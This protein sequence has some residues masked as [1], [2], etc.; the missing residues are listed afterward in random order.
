MTPLCGCCYFTKSRSGFDAETKHLPLLDVGAHATIVSTA[1]TTTLWQ[2]FANPS[3]T[4]EFS[5]CRY[6][7]P[8]H[9]GVRVISF[10]CE[11]GSRVIRGIVKEKVE[12]ENVYTEAFS[13]GET[14][15][16]LQQGPTSDVFVTT[17]GNIAAGEEV[18]VRIVYVGELKHDLALM[19]I[20]FTIPTYI[21]PRYGDGGSQMY[22]SSTSAE[23]I[24]ITV[25]ISMPS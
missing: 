15:G 19:C 12:A 6:V 10:N 7:F 14:A 25:D 1:S 11:V 13:R 3:S 17:I 21:S 4:E 9:D 20:R 18:R 23:R 2:T 16:L 5:E 24:S 8:L 22:S